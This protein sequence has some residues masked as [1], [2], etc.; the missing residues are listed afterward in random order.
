MYTY[1]FINKFYNTYF[2]LYK[3]IYLIFHK[4]HLNFIKYTTYKKTM[5]IYNYNE[6]IFNLNYFILNIRNKK[7]ENYK[8]VQYVKLEQRCITIIIRLDKIMVHSN[9]EII[10]KCIE[11][12]Y[13]SRTIHKCCMK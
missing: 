4:A 9:F 3:I 13:K 7:H 10:Y 2:I 12:L 6:Q 5:K 8:F 11:K 1:I